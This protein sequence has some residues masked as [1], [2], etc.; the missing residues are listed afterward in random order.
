MAD[1]RM[2]RWRAYLAIAAV[3]V[4]AA[5]WLYTGGPSYILQVDYQWIGDLA[6]SADV[7]IDGAVVG[8]LSFDPRGRPVQGFE[9]TPGEH[10]V[11]LRTRPCRARPEP[12]TVG[13]GRI[14]VV[15]ADLL[16]SSGGCTVV[17]H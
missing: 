10:V 15:V 9:V 8:H 3:I 2:M 1:L 7:V 14:T 12:V 17:F 5:W 6:D 16:E 4:V 13:P 11:E